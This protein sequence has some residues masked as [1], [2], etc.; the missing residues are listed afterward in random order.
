MMPP[1]SIENQE[2]MEHR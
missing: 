2:V 1:R